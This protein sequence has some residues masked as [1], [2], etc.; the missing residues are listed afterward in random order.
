VALRGTFV[1]TESHRSGARSAE[2]G[3]RLKPGLGERARDVE[4]LG[5]GDTTLWR[6]H[7]S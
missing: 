4:P 6:N 7:E 2:T 5:L 1:S 3:N